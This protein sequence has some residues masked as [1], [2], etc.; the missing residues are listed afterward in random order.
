MT[1]QQITTPE[2]R[3][4]VTPMTVVLSAEGTI[5]GRHPSG[6]AVLF[7][8]ENPVPWDTLALPLTVLWPLPIVDQRPT[9]EITGSPSGGTDTALKPVRLPAT[10][11]QITTAASAAGAGAEVAR[12][13]LYADAV[14]LAAQGDAAAPTVT[15]EQRLALARFLL[16]SKSGPENVAFYEREG[17]RMWVEALSAADVAL[18]TIGIEERS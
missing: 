9:V 10:G 16:G 12:E 1:R 17:G 15:A 4:A 7:G 18:A 11:G 13:A 2:E 3:A 14:N 8:V 5:A 6:A